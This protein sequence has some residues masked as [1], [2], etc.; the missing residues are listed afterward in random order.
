[1]EIERSW[2]EELPLI[3]V[4]TYPGFDGY[5]ML[6]PQ[7]HEDESVEEWSARCAVIYNLGKSK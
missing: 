6:I 4:V 1:M 3:E 5:A 2:I 7:R